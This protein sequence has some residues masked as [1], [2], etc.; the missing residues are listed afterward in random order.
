MLRTVAS[1]P[2]VG[3]L[4]SLSHHF[5]QAR[6]FAT[7]SSERSR[8]IGARNAVTSNRMQQRLSVGAKLRSNNQSTPGNAGWASWFQPE[9]GRPGVPES[10]R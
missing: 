10:N 8:P 9:H 2:H 4:V 1:W 5:G 6:K 3:L 7:R